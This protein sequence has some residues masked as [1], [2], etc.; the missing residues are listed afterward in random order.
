MNPPDRISQLMMA[1]AILNEITRQLPDFAAEEE[2][3]DLVCRLATQ[4]TETV[5]RIAAAQAQAE[6][7]DRAA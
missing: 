1:V 5:N 4:L 2:F 3:Y 7:E 6:A